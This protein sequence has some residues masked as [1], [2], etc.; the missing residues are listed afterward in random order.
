MTE[1][2]LLPAAGGDFL[3]LRF[4]A[5]VDEMHNIIIDSGYRSCFSDFNAIMKSI[6]RAKETIDAIVLTHIDH[7]HIGGFLCWLESTVTEYPAIERIYF[8]TGR[9][10]SEHMGDGRKVQEIYFED[11]IQGTPSNG[12]YSTKNAC[13]ILKLLQNKKLLDRLCPYSAAGDSPVV[14][15]CGASMRFISPSEKA[16]LAFGRLWRTAEKKPVVNYGGAEKMT[17]HG[18]IWTH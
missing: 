6:A 5:L 11:S 14:L 7:D 1:L 13:S 15:P 17:A 4:G 16:V 3:W 10:I 8:N 2:H 12:N 9:G 18:M